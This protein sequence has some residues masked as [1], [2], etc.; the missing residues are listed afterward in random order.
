MLRR[1]FSQL[2]VALGGL[3]VSLLFEL[4]LSGEQVRVRPAF[5]G[6]GTVASSASAA[7]GWPCE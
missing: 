3:F 2:L 6:P 4:D 5:L 7:S 1:D